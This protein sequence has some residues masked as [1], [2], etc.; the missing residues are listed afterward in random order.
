MRG[1]FRNGD[2]RLLFAGRVVT[3]VGDSLYFV[4]AMWLVYDLTD[5]PLYS[6]VAGFLTLAPSALQFLAGP[7]VDRWSIRAILTVTQVTQA[8]VVLVVPVAHVVGTLTPELILVVMPTLSL[9]NQLVYPAQSAALP[10]LLDDED[11]VAANS[12]FAVAYQGVD[13]VANALGGVAIALIGGVTL[14][15]IDAV[16]FGLAALLFVAIAVPAAGDGSGGQ[17]ATDADDGGD[18][19][20]DGDVALT[21]RG[22]ANPDTDAG[23]DSG[24]SPGGV[25]PASDGGG[26]Y[27]ADLLAGGRFVW[28]TF[29]VWLIGGAVAV[30][31][32]SG[33]ALATMPAYADGLS[34]MSLPAFSGGAGAYGVLMGAFAAGNFLGAAGA[35]AVAD[36]R[37]GRLMIAGFAVSGVAWTGAVLADW[38]PAT[39]ALLI[40]A[41]VPAGIVN[42]QLAAVVQSAVPEDLV[43]RVSSVLGSAT[44]TSIP[45]GALVGGAA[46]STLGPEATMSIN[47]AA[48][49]GL[50][51]YVLAV[52][53]LRRLP[54]A[55][56]V[57]LRS[58]SL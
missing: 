21:G 32:A 22:D 1:P 12:A 52:P 27:V 9:L 4:A 58:G 16:T 45:V 2:F 46:A 26:R 34:G 6:G 38:L 7:L 36:R 30:N 33:M 44:A 37:M 54:A 42:V 10:R 51:V 11:L 40:V 35:G 29:L 17:N 8:V 57:E 50:A 18:G 14:F 24:P 55:G 53:S 15:A 48:L 41:L 19:P 39:A 20:A 43:G 3:N 31:F 23:D 25:S 56:A 5:D 28:G 13:M 49:G 47:G